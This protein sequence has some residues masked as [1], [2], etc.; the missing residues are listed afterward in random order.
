[1]RIVIDTNVL[2]SGFLW[3]GIPH[4][5]IEQVRSN[6]VEMLVSA[7]LLEEFSQVIA[8]PKFASILQRTSRNPERI[9]DELRTL[10]DIV[11][12]PSL[13]QPVC[14]DPKD[15]IVLACALAAKANLLVSG[16]S[17]LLT[18][19]VFEGIP[20]VTPTEAVSIVGA[21]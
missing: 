13:P 3:G 9:F 4:T 6:A 7:A 21:G 1:M 8:R 15:D 14:R 19:K 17:D 20:I 10:A 18:L 11:I 5:L 12:A 2:L 16:D